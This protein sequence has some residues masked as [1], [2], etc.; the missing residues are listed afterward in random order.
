MKNA[1]SVKLPHYDV[2]HF[3]I[4][5]NSYW[6]STR[7]DYVA[8]SSGELRINFD[9]P[10]FFSVPLMHGTLAFLHFVIAA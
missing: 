8:G 9:P 3:A 5:N 4:F 1:K 10:G 7:H 2:P 6:C